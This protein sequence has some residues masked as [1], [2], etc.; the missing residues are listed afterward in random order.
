[1]RRGWLEGGTVNWQPKVAIGL[2]L[3]CAPPAAASAQ[4]ALPAGTGGLDAVVKEIR[5][6]RQELERQSATTTRAQLL[7]GRLTLQD[8]RSTRARQA[9]ERLESD[10]ARAEQS[11]Q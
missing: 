6:M 10:L 2:I 11:G 1:V 4:G 8:Q 9:V 5:L 7:I 3:A